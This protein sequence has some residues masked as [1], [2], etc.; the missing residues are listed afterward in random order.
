MNRSLGFT[1]SCKFP[2]PTTNVVDEG[3]AETA[4]TWTAEENRAGGEREQAGK[5]GRWWGCQ[6]DAAPSREPGTFSR[7]QST[8]G[9]TPPRGAKHPRRHQADEPVHFAQIWHS[10]IQ[11]G[12]V[13]TKWERCWKHLGKDWVLSQMAIFL[14]LDVGP[15][16][17]AT[18]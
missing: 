11:L 2:R 18:R 17:C 16:G 6:E 14:L 12:S 13:E 7:A 5:D 3:G 8:T 1:P 10:C 4:S 9:R 15:T